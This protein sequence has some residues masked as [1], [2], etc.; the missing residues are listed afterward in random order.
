MWSRQA[1]NRAIL[2]AVSC[3]A[4]L[5]VSQAKRAKSISSVGEFWTFV[6][7]VYAVVL[8]PV[9]L[10]FA[11]V[12]VRDPALREIFALVWGRIKRRTCRFLGPSARNTAIRQ[13]LQPPP[14]AGRRVEL[15][16]E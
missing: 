7:V 10:Y 3:S 16:Q 9:V 15:K 14:A 11:Y 12:A 13:S 8:L 6:A 4:V 5:S 1:A 2:T